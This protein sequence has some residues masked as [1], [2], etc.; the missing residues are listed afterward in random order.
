MKYKVEIKETDKEIILTF[1]GNN[2]MKR[3]KLMK[4]LKAKPL[5]IQV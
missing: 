1:A 2:E 3:E 4:I 5:K